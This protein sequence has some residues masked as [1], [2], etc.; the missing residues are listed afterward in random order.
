MKRLKQRL[1]TFGSVFVL[2]VALIVVSGLALADPK[3]MAVLAVLLCCG[4]AMIAPGQRMALRGMRGAIGATQGLV[5]TLLSG[6]AVATAFTIAK[7]GADDDHAIVA[8]AATDAFIGVFQHTGSA[9]EKEMDIMLSGI[10]DVI[11]GGAVTRGDSLTSDASGRAITATSDGQS[12][13]G[14][15][16]ISGVLNDKGAVILRRQTF[17]GIQAAAGNTF[18]QFAIATF[19]PSANAGER[20]IASHGLGVYLP[21]NA[22]ITRSWYEVL[23]TF[24]SAGADAGTIALG[25]PTDDVAGIVAALAISNGG[26]IWDAG[27]HE[28][29][30]DG[31]AANMGVKLTAERQLTADVAEQALT[32]GKLR[33]YVE[34]V[35]SV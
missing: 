25:I 35:I 29:I 30:Q 21:D 3:G 23:T 26:N 10:S 27:L 20:T 16:A 32:A 9:A 17:R 1:G 13:I 6:A 34:Y 11:Y 14:H 8:N 28:G 7:H 2:L 24:T 22:I 33:L 18:K 15:A 4:V 5:K 19:D 12:I 31:A